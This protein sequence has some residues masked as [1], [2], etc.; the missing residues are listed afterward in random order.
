MARRSDVIVSKSEQFKP[1]P[2]GAPSARPVAFALRCVIDLQLA[3][4]VRPLRPALLQLRGK[5]LD[6]GAGQSPWR[7]WL[8]PAAS[9]QGID[10]GHAGEFG[11]EANRNDVL[12]YDGRTMPLADASFDAALCIEVLEH[13]EDPEALLTE[14]ARVLRPQGRLLLTVP[15][16]ARRHHVPHD[17][18]RF[19]RE[20]LFKLLAAAGFGGIDISERGNDIGAIA[21]KLVVLSLR[22]A[23]PRHLLHVLWTWPLLALVGP[24]A[25]VFVAGFH[26]SEALGLGSR[27]DPLGYFA[28]ATRVVPVA[29]QSA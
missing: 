6:V 10:V 12:Y 8:P 2:V 5:V 27:D 21:N 17:Y 9:Y 19:T 26:G 14:I 11:M 25:V 4:I 24:V 7:D 13:A 22:L 15:W 28:S 29:E 20:R 3:T 1:I 18:H 16:S 23:R